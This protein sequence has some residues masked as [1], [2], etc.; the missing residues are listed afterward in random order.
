[1]SRDW[2]PRVTVATVVEQNGKFLMVEEDIYGEKI[3]NQPAGHLEPNES[4]IEAA[5]RETSEE[6]GWL[7]SIDHLIEFSQWTSNNSKN[8]YLRACFAATTTE[9]NPDQTLDEGIICA[10]WMTREEVAKNSHRLRSPLVL[11]HID[12]YIAGKKTDIDVFS[13]YD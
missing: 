8:H 9:F 5:I 2:L 1:M 12:H 3:L 13:Y 11:H 7:V 10:K 6:T 4:L